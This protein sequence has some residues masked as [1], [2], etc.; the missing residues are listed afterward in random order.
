MIPRKAPAKKR[1][2]SSQ[3]ARRL[4][5]PSNRPSRAHPLRT[6]TWPSVE[7]ILWEASPDADR[8]V[9]L[10]ND[11]RLET[12]PTM[13]PGSVR[14]YQQAA[15]TL[16]S[17][18]SFPD[19]L[20]GACSSSECA[21]DAAGE[22]RQTACLPRPPGCLL[23]AAS[24]C[25]PET[26]PPRPVSHQTFAPARPFGNNPVWTDRLGPPLPTR[27]RRVDLPSQ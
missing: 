7:E 2:D 19:T 9:V 17:T 12:P 16:A 21:S 26:C 8:C 14:R 18:G 4:R 10:T 6:R 3:R 11:R 24:R 15:R 22:I 20:D 1:S 25:G 23:P 13:L 27:K 5:R